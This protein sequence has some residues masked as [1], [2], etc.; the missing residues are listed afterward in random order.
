MATDRLRLDNPNEISQTFLETEDDQL[1]VTQHQPAWVNQAVLDQNAIDRSQGVN[2]MALGRHAA[3][4]PT[5]LRDMWR[6]EW[7]R[8]HADKWKWTTFL[9]MKLNS[10]DYKHLRTGV[11][12]L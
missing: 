1:I 7:Q 9:T 11:N 5:G 8:G 2:T 6:K 3:R 10:S 4:I 12:Q